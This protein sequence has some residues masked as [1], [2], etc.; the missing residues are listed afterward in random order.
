MLCT[1]GHEWSVHKPE[2]PCACRRTRCGCKFFQ[3]R[4]PG[5]GEPGGT[6]SVDLDFPEG[7][8]VVHGEASGYLHHFWVEGAT[9]CPIC[10]AEAPE[11][12]D[13]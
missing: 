7:P 11:E 12:D 10:G 8:F 4:L 5:D 13:A 1:C 2:E 9:V 3:P 6:G